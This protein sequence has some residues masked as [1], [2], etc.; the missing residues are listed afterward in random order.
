MKN[1]IKLYNYFWI[2]ILF[3]SIYFQIYI[4]ISYLLNQIFFFLI[5][6]FIMFLSLKISNGICKILCAPAIIN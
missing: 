6:S 4:N 1:K 3:I 5:N 2:L